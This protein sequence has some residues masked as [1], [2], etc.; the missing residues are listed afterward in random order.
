LGCNPK[1]K[2]QKHK[3]LLL[4]TVMLD[5]YRSSSVK[6]DNGKIG[7]HPWGRKTVSTLVEPNMCKEMKL[8]A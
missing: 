3:G 2:I 6:A 7:A 5:G 8:L 1:N 4:K